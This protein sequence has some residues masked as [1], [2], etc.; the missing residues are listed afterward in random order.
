M[1]SDAEMFFPGVGV[2]PRVCESPGVKFLFLVRFRC[3]LPLGV[4]SLLRDP[5]EVSMNACLSGVT[6]CRFGVYSVRDRFCWLRLDFLR[7]R[8]LPEV[9]VACKFL[10]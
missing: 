5:C 4:L 3:L 7:L 10:V 1:T 6:S 2:Y 8:L 9:G